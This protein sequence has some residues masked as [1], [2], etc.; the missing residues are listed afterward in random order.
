VARDVDSH[1]PR[2]IIIDHTHDRFET[3]SLAAYD[4]LWSD[5]TSLIVS[6][7]ENEQPTQVYRL[8]PAQPPQLVMTATNPDE[9]LLLSASRDRSLFVVERASPTRSTLHLYT[10]SSATKPAWSL[11]NQLPGSRCTS[12]R[13]TPVC[14]VFAD[15]PY[16][17]VVRLNGA[18]RQQ[19]EILYTGDAQNIPEHIDSDE[20]HLLVFIRQGTRTRLAIFRNSDSTPLIIESDGPVTTLLPAPR[21][22]SDSSH[23]AV[24]RRSF[25]KE[26]ATLSIPGLVQPATISPAAGHSTC[27]DCIE[28]ALEA[29]SIDGVSIPVSL[30]RPAQVRGL[31]V[32][33][34][35]AYGVS[36]AA[37]HSPLYNSLLRAGIAVAIA[38]VRGGSERGPGWHLQ[39]MAENKMG[40]V[41]DLLSVV[42]LLQTRLAVSP[43][44]TFLSGRS[45]GGW[46][47]TTAA[48]LAPSRIGGVILDAPLLDL[49]AAV[50]N[51]SVPLYHTEIAEWGKNP[52][53][54]LSVFPKA[55]SQKLPFDL[56]ILLPLKDRLIS[57]SQTARWAM[58]ARCAQQPGAEL[59][60]QQLA[61][62]GHTGTDSRVDVTEWEILQELFIRRSMQP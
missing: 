5:N 2:L 24:R 48:L 57:P 9:S 30:V 16:G 51:P 47:V 45:A 6:T 15:S 52:L 26:T 13:G 43:R 49:A 46:L 61:K 37:E 35:G 11:P 25:R 20:E 18:D 36:L 14:I 21:L 42:T 56:L 23:A 3:Y 10:Q 19:R 58:A 12:W 54:N 17:Q 7:L 31:L 33:A 32:I 60:V 28:E 59:L 39:A 62:A 29:P 38:H 50:S 4:L 34:Y 22:G 55:P 1:E 41:H 27:L 8:T 44:A 53:H 40:S